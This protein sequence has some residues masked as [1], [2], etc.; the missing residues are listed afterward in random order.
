M[1]AV[2]S[3]PAGTNAGYFQLCDDNGKMLC[4]VSASG[5]AQQRRRKLRLWKRDYVVMQFNPDTR[6]PRFVR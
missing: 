3:S 1:S 2:S 5:N 4:A 6:K